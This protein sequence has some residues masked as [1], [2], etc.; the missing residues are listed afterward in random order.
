MTAKKATLMHL[1][2]EWALANDCAARYLDLKKERAKES[3][4]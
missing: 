2:G 1:S 3:M 4:G